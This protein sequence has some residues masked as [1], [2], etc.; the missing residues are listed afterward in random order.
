MDKLKDTIRDNII[1]L[2]LDEE[3]D[4]LTVVVQ[5]GE[6]VDHMILFWFVWK[7]IYPEAQV[8]Q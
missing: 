6:S 3:T 7:S 5:F 8:H 4:N 1:T 2:K